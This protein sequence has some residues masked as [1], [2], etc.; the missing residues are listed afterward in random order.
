MSTHR[1]STRER[2]AVRGYS[3]LVCLSFAHG[4][5]SLVCKYGVISVS[6]YLFCILSS[7]ISLDW[8]L[9][10]L[11]TNDGE[12]NSAGGFVI[13]SWKYISVNKHLRC[14]ADGLRASPISV[15]R[16]Q[17]ALMVVPIAFNVFHDLILQEL[18]NDCFYFVFILNSKDVYGFCCK[19]LSQYPF[20]APKSI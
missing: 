17:S 2:A 4:S 15:S 9:W 13:L 14:W 18:Q 5:S 8:H 19:I 10:I 20:I 11:Y 7:T 12:N 6:I 3:D 1:E 16:C